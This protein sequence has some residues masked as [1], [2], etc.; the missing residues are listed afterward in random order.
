MTLSFAQ[1]RLVGQIYTD[2]GP[3]P[4]HQSRMGGR[5]FLIRWLTLRPGGKDTNFPPRPASA[6]AL[7]QARG[8]PGKDR[9]TP[10]FEK[11]L[12]V[13]I[14]RVLTGAPSG[15][16]ADGERAERGGHT[17]EAR[18]SAVKVIDPGDCHLQG[19]P[20]VKQRT[21]VF[22]ISWMISLGL[23]LPLVTTSPLSLLL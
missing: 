2:Q 22:Q 20:L 5:A 7:C 14:C 13:Q 17:W 19:M 16:F 6:R 9:L 18:V 10:A 4:H 12:C 3:G 11:S 21:G 1:A 15:I 8:H 23:A